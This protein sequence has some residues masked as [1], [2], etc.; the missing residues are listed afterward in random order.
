MNGEPQPP[1]VSVM[2]IVPDAAAAASWYGEAFGATELWNLGSVRGLTIAGAPF[3]LHEAVPTNSHEGTPQ[4][5]GATTTR[6]EIFVEDPDAFLARAAAAQ[7]ATVSPPQD[8]EMPWGNHR[9]G[10]VHDPFGHVWSVG[11]RSPLNPGGV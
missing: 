4:Q 3:F 8:H 10:A 6:I 9:Q 5:L 7:P 2:L 1:V 11:D